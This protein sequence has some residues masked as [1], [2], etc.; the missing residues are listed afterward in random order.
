MNERFSYPLTLVVCALSGCTSSVFTATGVAPAV[1]TAQVT[2]DPDDPA[3]WIHPTDPSASLIIGTNKVQAPNGALVIFGLNG[4][5]RQTVA[6]LDR[7]NN[8]DIEY[9]LKM[10]EGTIDV[11][12]T[13]ERLKSR[14]RV[15]RITPDGNGSP[16]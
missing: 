13:T 15:F 2:D 11:A 6:G 10:G 14:L 9:G 4:A 12:V 5:A 3:I 16:T 1:W 8:V 7:P